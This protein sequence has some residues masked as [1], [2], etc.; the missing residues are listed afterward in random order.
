[1]STD[2]QTSDLKM[3]T[4]QYST[5]ESE[6]VIDHDSG[7]HGMPG[8]YFK[9]EIDAICVKV[10]EEYAPFWMFLI[11]LCGIVGGIYA[12]SGLISSVA[13]TV[14][15]VIT[16]KY[17]E[18]NITIKDVDNKGFQTVQDFSVPSDSVSLLYTENQ[19]LQQNG[20]VQWFLIKL[21]I[22]YWIFKWI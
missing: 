18:S 11:R 16:C 7:S 20:T 15:D 10:V 4:Y 13:N 12:T 5:T 21:F 3:K 14:V 17:I 9:Y 8:I 1:M 22:I 2:V 19:S 6:R